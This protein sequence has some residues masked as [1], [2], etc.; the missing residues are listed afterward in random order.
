MRTM[1]K[2]TAVLALMTVLVV[3]MGLSSVAATPG[4]GPNEVGADKKM[5]TVAGNSTNQY[6]FRNQFQFQLRVNQSTEVNIDCEDDG[7]GDREFE[8]DL[9]TSKPVSIEMTIRTENSDIGLTDGSTVQSRNQNQN[10]NQNQYR[11]QEQFMINVTLNESCDVQAR[12]A[13]NSED[14]NAT[15]AYYDED[16]EEFVPVASSFENGMVVAYT[17]HFSTWTLLTYDD[18][19]TIPGYS[20]LAFPAILALAGMVF[21]IKK[22]RA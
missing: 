21:L 18:G 11:Y 20:Y 2:K 10:Q 17:N 22:K 9:N 1:L 13:I 14:S 7:L 8:M 12:L 3:T 15:W 16:T 19:T 5:D 6:Q 4:P